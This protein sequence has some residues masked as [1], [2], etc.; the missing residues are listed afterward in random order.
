MVAKA[1]VCSQVLTTTASKALGWSN[2]LRKSENLFA[3]GYL[4]AAALRLLALTSQRA[5]MFSVET[6]AKLL[7]PRPPVPMTAMLSFELRFCPRRK[8]G[9]APTKI[10]AKPVFLANCR[11]FIALPG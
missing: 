1:W 7:P 8:A 2:T 10:A 3:D 5:T 4:A 6:L 9:A 11:R